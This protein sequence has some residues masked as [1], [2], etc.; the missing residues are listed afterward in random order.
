MTGQHHHHEHGHSHGHGHTHGSGRTLLFSL[1]FTAAFA[2]VELIGGWW[3]GSLALLSDAGHMITDSSSL[4]IGA[5]AV[6]LSRWP[7]SRQHSFGF[8]RAEILGALV[9]VLFMFAVVVA[10]AVSGF[11]RLLNP[12]PVDGWIVVVIA[13]IGLL[14]NIIVAA[15][16]MRGEETM[17]VRG[18][19][20]HV[21][22]DLFGSIA[23]II[24]GTVIMLTGWMPI[25]PLL[26]LLV[27]V[28]I[29]VSAGKL[30]REV[31]KVLMEGVPEGVDAD[32]VSAAMTE[33]DGVRAVHDLH[34]WTLSS[35]QFAL[36][37]HVDVNALRSWQQL[38]PQ[39]QQL[40]R[41]RFG[42]EHT[43]LQPEDPALNRDCDSDPNCGENFDQASRP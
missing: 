39:L 40:L 29:L 2:I 24:A 10:I 19:L 16:L 3:S 7:A 21:M 17:N 41:E 26:S 20:L 5:V 8:Q 27:A 15:I 34:I 30:L 31:L 13:S 18:A 35:S 32:E 23:A 14:M 38:L 42:I 37:A 12:S 9:N 25:D 36:A 43:T 28:L 11:Q 22:G 6:W 33:V 4:A 1:C